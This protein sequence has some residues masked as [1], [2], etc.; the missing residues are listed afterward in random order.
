MGCYKG[1]AEEMIQT[2]L[3]KI[4]ISVDRAAIER[5]VADLQRKY[6][7]RPRPG[8]LR[9]S[10]FADIMNSKAARQGWLC[11]IASLAPG[12]LSVPAEAGKLVAQWMTKAQV[13]YA[14]ACI[15]GRKPASSEGFQ[16]A[17]F[18][19]IAGDK[20]V[21]DAAK[22][23]GVDWGTLIDIGEDLI[24]KAFK[25]PAVQKKLIEKLGTKVVGG[26]AAVG[27]AYGAG[28][29]AAEFAGKLVA[30]ISAFKDGIDA[31]MDIASVAK[32]AQKYYYKFPNPEGTYLV[33]DFGAALS[34]GKNGSVAVRPRMQ[35][36]FT[37]KNADVREGVTLGTG[38]YTRNGDYITITLGSVS[39]EKSQWNAP[40][41]TATNDQIDFANVEPV[42]SNK[43]LTAQITGDEKLTFSLRLN[44]P[45]E[46]TR[47]W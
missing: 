42:L 32:A 3:E 40:R 39:W 10:V 21:Y 26:M 9:D 30:P 27:A 23:L 18:T 41:P 15:Y 6:S 29:T 28:K 8:A 37:T 47:I 38:N 2:S 4:V 13:A 14:V 34:F 16:I 20:L 1:F 22:E 17:L 35:R 7:D 11:G 25:N 19:L 43:T 24:V 31:A 36:G 33:G 45:P 5:Q 44:Q 46:W 12:A